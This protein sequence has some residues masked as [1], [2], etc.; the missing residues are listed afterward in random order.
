M[1]EGKFL[2]K[3]ME[4]WQ[5]YLTNT[6]DPDAQANRFV[7]LIDDLSYS[8]T[9]YP[10]STTTEFLNGLGAKAYTAIYSNKKQKSNRFIWFW[11]YELPAIMGKYQKHYMFTLL[12]F[13]IMVTIGVVASINDRDFVT[14][15]LGSGYVEMTQN[16]IDNGKPFDVYANESAFKMFYEIAFNN[17]MVSFYV[18][19]GGLLAGIGTLKGLFENGIMLGTFQH[20]FFAKGLGWDSILCVWTHGALEIN[21]IVLAGTAGLILGLSYV[22]PGTYGRLD[23]FKK[24]AKDA[25]KILIGLIPIFLL[26][27]YL[28]GYI[29]RHTEYPVWLSII[30]LTV[31]EGFILWYFIIYPLRLK[32]QNT[33]VL[34]GEL[35]KQGKKVEI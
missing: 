18:F 10:R 28:E 16:N 3:N 35:Y 15:I 13:T 30:I 22:F 20:M 19:T 8:K 5:S 33:Y 24:C 14:S 21:A 31:S 27:A 7:N 32:K 9:F 12:F 2:K 4:R 23:N 26:A 1:R 34:N 11:Q 25:I 6:D 17:I 29:T